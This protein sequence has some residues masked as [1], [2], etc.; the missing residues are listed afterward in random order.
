[1]SSE[2]QK[3]PVASMTPLLALMRM[4]AP[5]LLATTPTT[6]PSAPRTNSLRAQLNSV[7]TVPSATLALMHS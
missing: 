5:S 7:S 4:S 1:M 3:P 2:A 6:A